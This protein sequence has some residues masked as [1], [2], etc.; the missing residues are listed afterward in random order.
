MMKQVCK[1]IC[2]DGLMVSLSFYAM[3][4]A[5]QYTAKIRNW[6]ICH[7]NAPL[8]RNSLLQLS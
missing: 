7:T 2:N 6:F 4:L 3:L 8:S 5:L 1:T